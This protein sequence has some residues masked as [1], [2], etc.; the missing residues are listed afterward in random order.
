MF[1]SLER[2]QVPVV[3]A[4]NGTALGSGFELCLATHHRVCINDP[5]IMLGSP[6]VSLGLM[7]GGGGLIRTLWKLGI[8]PTIELLTKGRLLNPLEARDLNL[9]DEL[10]YDRG[11]MMRKARLWIEQ[12][13][14]PKQPWDQVGNAIPGLPADHP[15]VR[16]AVALASARLF[17]ETRGN[18]PAPQKILET[19]V[20]AAGLDFDTGMQIEARN[21]TE[22][23]A[24]QT[25]KNLMKAFWFDFNAIKAASSRPKGYGRFRPYKVGI[26]G[27]GM[28]GS[29]IA[30][31]CAKAGLKVVLKDVS[32]VIADKGK[33]YS[34]RLL[35]IEVETGKITDDD[36]ELILQKIQ[37][38]ESASDFEDCDLVI[39]AVFENR[40]LKGQVTREA[41]QFL[42]SETLVA[43]NT[44]TIPITDLA[45]SSMRPENFIGMHFFS[46]VEKMQLVEI[47]KGEATTRETLARAFDF[48]KQ[49]GKTPIVVN[50]RRGFYTTR[51]LNRFILEGLAL[52]QEGQKAATI[53]QI[54]LLSG[55]P[56][57]P[58]A[59]SD[60]VSIRLLR[61]IETQAERDLGEAYEMH[62]GFPVLD[63]MIDELDRV[64]KSKKAG[65]YEYPDA[66]EKYL[67]EGLSYHFPVAAEQLALETITHRLMFSQVLEA[68]RCYEEGV[69][70]AVH[71]ANVGA[72]LGWGFA[73][74]KGGT[75]QYVNDFG[76]SAF[77]EVAKD[78]EARFG[79]RFKVPELLFEME[80]SGSA[81]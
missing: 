77:I 43:S 27:A 7:P 39:E 71:D 14:S 33:Q 51:V 57:G 69:V 64:G 70:M 22:L 29:G 16:A 8:L 75:L 78:L 9:V 30:H 35:E 3:A 74:F 50:D 63:K 42:H 13:D 60:E 49:V 76:I 62:P 2:L 18:Y 37:T 58:L 73:P 11:D 32:R 12:Q 56:V 1:R 36:K 72:I 19:I 59:L 41:D 31:I 44:S 17:K 21:F 38:T 54:S 25:A 48:V 5:N 68:V 40:M 81:F 67:W 24:G 4:I 52:L 46:P 79:A 80:K 20:E 23:I 47:I 10:A 61:D 53:E 65:F 45:K 6:E 28:M 66:E 55:M 26:I 15:E 34:A